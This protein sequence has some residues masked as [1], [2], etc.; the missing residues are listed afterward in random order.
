MMMM[1][2]DE[3]AKT[4][5]KNTG[6]RGT[7]ENVKQSKFAQQKNAC[8]YRGNST[9]G[10]TCIVMQWALPIEDALVSL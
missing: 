8:I 1:M 4:K 5:T 7:N 9:T 3:T 6:R 10:N 2:N